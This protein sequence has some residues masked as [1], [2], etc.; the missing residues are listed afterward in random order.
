MRL[1]NIS[2]KKIKKHQL[3]LFFGI[4][5]ASITM[6]ALQIF[7]LILSIYLATLLSQLINYSLGLFFYGKAVFKVKKLSIKVAIRYLFLSIFLWLINFFGITIIV[8][9]GLLENLA[10]ILMALPIALISYFIQKK[11]VFKN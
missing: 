2:A 5:N 4:L 9:Q 7:L 10:A 1:K 3:F 6:I 11:L 8:N